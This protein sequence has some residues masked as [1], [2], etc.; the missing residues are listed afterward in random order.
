M[1]ISREWAHTEISET[2]SNPITMNLRALFFHESN[3]II[4]RMHKCRGR[5]RD[6]LIPWRNT[7]KRIHMNDQLCDQRGHLSNRITRLRSFHMSVRPLVACIGNGRLSF[8]SKSSAPQ[9]IPISL[10]IPYKFIWDR[11]RSSIY[12]LNTVLLLCRWKGQTFQ[13]CALQCF[14]I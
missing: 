3:Y 5:E 1:Y 11:V 12:G 9:T 8:K 10:L 14:N 4:S 6:R 7:E 13:N 2:L